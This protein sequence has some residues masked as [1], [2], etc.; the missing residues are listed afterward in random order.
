MG[1]L[2]GVLLGMCFFELTNTLFNP[3]LCTRKGAENMFQVK[4]Y[5]DSFKADSAQIFEKAIEEWGLEAFTVQFKRT[6]PD[7][8]EVV[9]FIQDKSESIKRVHR[10]GTCSALW[11]IPLMH[12]IIEVKDTKARRVVKYHLGEL[13]GDSE[14][15]EIKIIK[16][17]EGE[18]LSQRN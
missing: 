4:I 8:K 13:N 17:L 14:S 5:Y 16:D 7:I 9:A 3:L 15:I 11:H 1:T 6:T 18:Q 12:Y 2:I 10:T